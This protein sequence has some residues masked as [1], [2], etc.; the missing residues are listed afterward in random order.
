MT[1]SMGLGLISFADCFVEL[2][3]DL[4]VLLGDRF[5]IFSA[6]TAATVAKIPIAHIHGGETTE[7]AFDEAFRHSITKMS[8]LHFTTTEKYRKRT[9]QLGESPQAGSSTLAHL[10][11]IS[12]LSLLSREEFEDLIG[13]K[14]EKKELINHLSPCHIG[15]IVLV[16]KSIW[17]LTFGSIHLVKLG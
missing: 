3:P 17:K 2:K 13:F 5:E 15:R 16:G 14:L 11:N 4:V 9:I 10:D 12:N 8:H 6:A 1:K 7:G